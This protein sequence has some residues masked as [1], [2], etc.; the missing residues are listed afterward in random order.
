MNA[1]VLASATRQA[2][3]IVRHLTAI[4]EGRRCPCSTWMW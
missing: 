1:G 4:A 2:E 3:R